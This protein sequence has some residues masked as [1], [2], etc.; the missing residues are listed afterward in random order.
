MS[1]ELYFSL[2]LNSKAIVQSAIVK[3]YDLNLRPQGSE[4]QHFTVTKRSFR[5]K[6]V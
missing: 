4:F 5:T 1:Q 6:Q 2:A 3:A